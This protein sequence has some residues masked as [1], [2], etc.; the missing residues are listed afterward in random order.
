[1]PKNTA[2]M[3]KKLLMDSE[4]KRQKPLPINILNL[5]K[6]LKAYVEPIYGSS[7]EAEK[8][9]DEITA[10]Y[11]KGDKP[12]DLQIASN[13]VIIEMFD[14]HGMPLIENFMD[15]IHEAHS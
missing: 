10:T 3:T 1:M 2:I 5:A 12:E 7:A 4:N 11:F 15:L 8:V 14:N 9:V 13:Q 6:D